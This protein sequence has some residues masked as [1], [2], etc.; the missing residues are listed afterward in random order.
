M[1]VV[2]KNMTTLQPGV[3]VR[4]PHAN[5]LDTIKASSGTAAACSSVGDYEDHAI[6]PG[7]EWHE[8]SHDERKT[9]LEPDPGS[10]EHTTIKIATLPSEI[11]AGFLEV[12]EFATYSCLEDV[13]RRVSHPTFRRAI[14]VCSSYVKDQFRLAISTDPD[15]IT[16]GIRVN[17]GNLRTVTVHPGT[18]R[19]VGMHV[20]NWSRL[21]LNQRHSAPQRICVNLGNHPRYFLFVNISIRQLLAAAF[22][23]PAADVDAHGCDTMIRWS[24]LPSH[25]RS[26]SGTAV[27]RAFMTSSPGYPVIR[28][29]LKPGEAYI[30]PT[31][32]LI[33][34][35][36]SLGSRGHDISLSL[37]EET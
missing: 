15:H 29:K 11:L 19:F 27:G 2:W 10:E 30:A 25:D 12:R 13:R 37:R 4:I 22:R 14:S 21:P 34:D 8:L 33:H 23:A 35:G 16:G 3:T 32:N 26:G 20:D 1:T 36:S 9:L 28:L 18:E 24:Q 7:R 6:I 17:A 31:E 5:D